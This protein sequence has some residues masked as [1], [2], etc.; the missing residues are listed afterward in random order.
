MNCRLPR[1]AEFKTKL[2]FN[3][4]DLIMTKCQSVLKKE[5]IYK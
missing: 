1:A 2:G 3:K 5:N 4:H